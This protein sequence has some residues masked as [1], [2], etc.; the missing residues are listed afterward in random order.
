METN[1]FNS[2]YLIFSHGS[3]MEPTN[4]NYVVPANYRLVTLYASGKEIKENLVK[5]IL[6]QIQKKAHGINNLF[7]IK[8]PIARNTV[9][10]YLENLFIIDYLKSLFQLDK[11]RSNKIKAHLDEYFIKY[12]PDKS[13]ESLEDLNELLTNQNYDVIKNL[14]GLEIKIHRPGDSCPKI[15]LDFTFGKSLT[16]FPSGIFDT[17]LLENLNYD[18]TIELIEL[19]DLDKNTNKGNDDGKAT[20]KSLVNFENKSYVLD[21]KLQA[22]DLLPFFNK[23]KEIVPNG[24]LILLSGDSFNKSQTLIQR[25]DSNLEQ[26][27]I[28]KKYYINYN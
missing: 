23:I 27:L 1:N 19:I 7:N 4:D 26:K 28:Y 24:L 18:K 3:K 10:I 25:K 2:S 20:I 12:D 5:L 9:R 14:L 17:K 21:S 15:L 13:I 22:P 16:K 6:T 8:C 11:N